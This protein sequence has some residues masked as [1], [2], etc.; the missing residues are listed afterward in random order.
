MDSVNEDAE[1]NVLLLGIVYS[2]PVNKSPA[3]SHQV[4]RDRIRCLSME[5]NLKYNV[6]SM[7]DKHIPESAVRGKHCQSN[8]SDPCR[9]FRNLKST[10]GS[11][12]TFK[13]ICLDYFFSPQGWAG[14]RWTKRFFT[15]TIPLLCEKGFLKKGSSIWL[16]NIPHVAEMI[17]DHMGIIS[18]HYIVE[19][20]EDPQKNPLFLATDHC[21]SELEKCTDVVTNSNELPKLNKKFPF[22]RLTVF[23]KT[24]KS[25]TTAASD[26]SCMVSIKKRKFAMNG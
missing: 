26:E 8:F 22:Y 1:G 10:W 5:Q 19:A 3:W 11:M 21:K 16:P 23:D 12:T 6:F 2:A 20:V 25:V 14:D 15:G 17:E 18:Q 9:L 24:T 13:H 4:P 7:D